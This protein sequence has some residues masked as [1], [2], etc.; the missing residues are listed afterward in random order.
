MSQLASK[1]DLAALK[2]DF[3]YTPDRHR[4]PAWAFPKSAGAGHKRQ[5]PLKPQHSVSI[6][7]MM[8]IEPAKT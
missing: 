6:R 2:C 1:A 5:R 8:L 7:M 4:P 3:R